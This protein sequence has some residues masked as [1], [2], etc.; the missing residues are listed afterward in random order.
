MK[1]HLKIKGRIACGSRNT[2]SIGMIAVNY[3]KF[4]ETA[5]TC[6]ESVCQRCLAKWKKIKMVTDRNNRA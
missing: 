6:P 2:R 4:S 3:D 1:D 5:L